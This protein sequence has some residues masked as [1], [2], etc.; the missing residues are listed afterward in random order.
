MMRTDVTSSLLHQRV[1]PCSDR[2][3]FYPHDNPSFSVR[4]CLVGDGG[5]EKVDGLQVCPTRM[6]G[7]CAECRRSLW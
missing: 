2:V 7:L 1:D 3:Y 4:D 5:G 6:G